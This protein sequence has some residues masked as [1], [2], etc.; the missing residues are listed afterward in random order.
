MNLAGT[1]PYNAFGI[2]KLLFT[3]LPAAITQFFGICT[4]PTT[5][6]FAA[7][8]TPSSMRTG[9]PVCERYLCCAFSE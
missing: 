9:P 7:I 1:P 2:D 4:P 5:T 3:T 6:Q 8:H